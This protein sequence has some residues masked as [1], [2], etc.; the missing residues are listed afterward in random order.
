LQE[1]HNDAKKNAIM[2]KKN[3]ENAKIYIFDWGAMAL[4]LFLISPQR[5]RRPYRTAFSNRKTPYGTVAGVSWP[6]RTGFRVSYR[7]P[8]RNRG[9]GRFLQLNLM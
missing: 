1:K 2:N 7:F 8:A 6:Y 4:F 9:G 3:I 5:H